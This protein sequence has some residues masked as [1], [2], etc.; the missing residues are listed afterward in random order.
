MTFSLTY[1]NFLLLI[2]F[3]GRAFD[4]ATWNSGQLTQDQKAEMLDETVGILSRAHN[5]YHGDVFV[6]KEKM[7][8]KLER[9]E[10]NGQVHHIIR[11]EHETL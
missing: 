10:V 8:D 5:M 11:R 4:L 7:K 9:R 6:A 3:P 1:F 2:S